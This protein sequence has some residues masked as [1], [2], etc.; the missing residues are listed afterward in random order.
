MNADVTPPTPPW[1]PGAVSEKLAAVDDPMEP[2]YRF[3]L[4]NERTFLAWQRTSLGLLAAAV[5]VVQFMPEL[6]M[7]GVRHILGVAVGAL[8][9]LTAIAGLRRWAQVDRAMRHDQPLPRAAVPAYLTA[10][11]ATM[12][13]VT[14]GVAVAATL[15]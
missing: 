11:L 3:T 7:P 6:T 2:D 4:A 15:R 10:A 1:K 13:L 14:V 9:I 8:A 12:G 5:A